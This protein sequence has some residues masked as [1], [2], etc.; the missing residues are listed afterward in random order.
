MRLQA[1]EAAPEQAVRGRREVQARAQAVSRAGEPV[2]VGVGSECRIVGEGRGGVVNRGIGLQG[3]RDHLAVAGHK[4]DRKV[5]A[6]QQRV[7]QTDPHAVTDLAEGV[8]RQSRHL[9]H[10]GA[11]RPVLVRILRPEIPTLIEAPARGEHRAVVPGI[12]IAILVAR[13]RNRHRGA[14][15][16]CERAQSPFLLQRDCGVE[17]NIVETGELVVRL[18]AE[19]AADRHA[20]S[21]RPTEKT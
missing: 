9:P 10:P 4:A 6:L 14:H 12:A 19:V 16:R 17:G 7:F 21:H 2:G 8:A 11:C 15:P 13:S 1:L 20:V 3:R 18:P 5:G